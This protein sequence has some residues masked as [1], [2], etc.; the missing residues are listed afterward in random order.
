MTHESC[1]M[2]CALVTWLTT[3]HWFISDMTHESCNMTCALVTWLV[4][5]RTKWRGTCCAVTWMSH[6]ATYEWVMSLMNESCHII[7]QVSHLLVPHMMCAMMCDVMHM[8]SKTCDIS[9]QKSYICR[10]VPAY[11]CIMCDISAYTWL[12]IYVYD[13]WY[14]CTH[15]YIW[16]HALLTSSCHIWMSLVTPRHESCRT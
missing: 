8:W 3:R 14:F 4:L 12:C 1:N 13:V 11:I 7:R 16:T 6:E 10:N 5:C 2:T 9:M 15:M